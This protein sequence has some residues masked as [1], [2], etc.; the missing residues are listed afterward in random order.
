MSFFFFFNIIH[1]CAHNGT[2]L[3]PS[4]LARYRLVYGRSSTTPLQTRKTLKVTGMNDVITGRLPQ[5]YQ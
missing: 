2:S 5:T 3:R 4:D 1:K